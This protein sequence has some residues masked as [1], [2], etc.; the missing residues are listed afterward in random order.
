M[1]NWTE[2]ELYVKGPQADRD[3]FVNAAEA[4]HV[5]YD[6]IAGED[7]SC[8]TQLDFNNFIPY[9]KH[10]L[11]QDEKAKA[12]RK[13]DPKDW[14]VPD[15]FNCGG[16]DWCINNWGTKWN[17]CEITLTEN[18]TSLKYRFDTAWSP[19][20][21]VVT[22]MAHMFPMLTFTLKYFEGGIGFQGRYTIKGDEI[23]EE[24]SGDYHGNRGG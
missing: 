17:A 19:P 1:P 15:G 4:H 9:P 14:S 10:Y 23:I 21:K 24:F 12:A 20:I 6:M 13:K 8:V 16:Y 11:D 22:A 3:A 7:Y 18:K 2:N 5:G